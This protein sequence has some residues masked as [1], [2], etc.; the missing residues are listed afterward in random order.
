[1]SRDILSELFTPVDRLGMLMFKFDR[2]LQ[3]SQLSPQNLK[4]GQE[5]GSSVQIFS[6]HTTKLYHGSSTPKI[7]A[8][9]NVGR[10]A[11]YKKESNIHSVCRSSPPTLHGQRFLPIAHFSR[12]YCCCRCRLLLPAFN[13]IQQIPHTIFD[14]SITCEAFCYVQYAQ[15][16]Q[17]RQVDTRHHL[18]VGQTSGII[19]THSTARVPPLRLRPPS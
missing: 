5:K 19:V 8:N 14:T 3:T 4:Y 17:Q 12:M 1:M 9:S 18:P 13:R 11:A 7:F 15:L 6:P 16:L 2:L 10:S